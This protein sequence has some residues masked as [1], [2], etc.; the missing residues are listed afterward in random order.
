MAA[1]A[2]RQAA[3]SPPSSLPL[4]PRRPTGAGVVVSPGTVSILAPRPA[5]LAQVSRRMCRRR[6]G[7]RPGASRTSPAAPRA[8]CRDSSPHAA[9]A[10]GSLCGLRWT[11]V[12]SQAGSAAF[13]VGPRMHDGS[14]RSPGPVRPRFEAVGARRIRWT[15]LVPWLVSRASGGATAAAF[16]PS[17]PWHS[18]LVLA[19]AASPSRSIPSASDSDGDPSQT[20][21]GARTPQ[22]LSVNRWLPN[23]RAFSPHP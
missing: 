19:L 22:A 1:S 15:L 6:P 21:V 16:A 5:P 23:I 20:L 12:P 7:D 11:S 10:S 13:L 18:A 8:V 9:T 3:S 4:R 17:A 14:R 2:R